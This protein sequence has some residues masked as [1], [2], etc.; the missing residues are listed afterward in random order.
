MRF[1]EPPRGPGKGSR[2]R[3]AGADPALRF[4]ALSHGWSWTF[5]GLAIVSG[6]PVW[7]SS[8]R[9]LLFAGGLGPALAG[10]FMTWRTGGA[11]G[12]RDL[13][14]R[15][16]RVRRIGTR[17]MAVLLAIPP[18]AMAGGALLAR[19][20]PGNAAVDTDQLT[21]LLGDPLALLGFAV[22]V[23]LLGPVPE[24]IGWR[25]FLL[26]ALQARRDAVSASLLLGLAWA[27]WHL[28]LFFMA[29]YYADGAPE[30]VLF[31]AAILANSV[32][33]TWI[34]NNTGRSVLAA[35]LFHFGINF[36][37]MLFEGS[38]AVEWSRTLVTAAIAGAV[39]VRFGA[40]T[41]HRPR[42]AAPGVLR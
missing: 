11:A 7:D 17:W 13:G 37:G 6:G 32:L 2:G 28:P 29:G 36:V 41:L 5:W 3:R 14:L 33:Y 27:L 34:Y 35:I 24:E 8:A 19:L 22:A 30:P 39:I 15:L 4:L 18:A 20:G 1:R 42:L 21:A 10:I 31:T 38:P 40:R 25:G 12:L 9:Y 16:I 23:L 26:D